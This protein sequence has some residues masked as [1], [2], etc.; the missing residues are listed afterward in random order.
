MKDNLRKAHR[1]S[2]YNYNIFLDTIE[3]AVKT[4]LNKI[5]HRKSHKTESLSKKNNE[6]N[7]EK[8]IYKLSKISIE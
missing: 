2:I 3:V 5:T 1:G 8:N 4:L 6:Q 7:Q